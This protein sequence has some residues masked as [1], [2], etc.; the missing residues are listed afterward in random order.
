MGIYSSAPEV[1][2]SLV[3][4]KAE[5]VYVLTRLT[6]EIDPNDNDTRLELVEM[7]HYCTLVKD[8]IAA[9]AR[10]GELSFGA[11]GMPKKEE[12]KSVAARIVEFKKQFPTL[13]EAEIREI[14]EN[15][16]R[17][18]AE[19]APQPPPEPPAFVVKREMDEN[20]PKAR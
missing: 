10:N 14:V 7:R 9:A 18:S 13:T 17:E 1:L 4:T 16:K 12:A 6:A 5:L 8:R 11:C 2:P 19:T 15:A 3:F 20:T